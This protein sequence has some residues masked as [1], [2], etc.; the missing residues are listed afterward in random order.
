MV[1]SPSSRLSLE[2]A[3]YGEDAYPLLAISPE[4]RVRLRNDQVTLFDAARKGDIHAQAILVTL[5][6]GLVRHIV[7]YEFGDVILCK[8]APPEDILAAGHFGLLKATRGY[9]PSEGTPFWGYA[10]KAIY[11]EAARELGEWD[12]TPVHIVRETDQLLTHFCGDM[13]RYE[14]DE[15][16]VSSFLK[17]RSLNGSRYALLRDALSVPNGDC[18]DPNSIAVPSMIEEE[19]ETRE[20]DDCL[21]M[22]LGEAVHLYLC[23]ISNARE[24]RI[25]RCALECISDGVPFSAVEKW[26]DCGRANVSKVY[27]AHLLRLKEFLELKGIAD[28]YLDRSA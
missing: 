15:D 21:E 3:I 18:S 20:H 16:P 28:K 5:H 6:T 4:E 7:Y 24:R 22:D 19:V 13:W 26:L 14:R 25:F 1:A 12:A 17:E 11:R 9:D 27:R 23:T 10:N 8:G 2:K